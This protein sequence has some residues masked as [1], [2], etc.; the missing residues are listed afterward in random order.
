MFQ[1]AFVGALRLLY[2]NFAYLRSKRNLVK[3]ST[4]NTIN[5][6][7]Q[8]AR[9]WVYQSN[10]LLTDELIRIL[11]EKGKNFVESWTAHGAALKTSFDILYNRF[12]V[13]S[14]DEQQ[15]QASGCSIDKSI[16]FMKNLE[17]EFQLQLFDRMQ[18]AFRKD[19]KIEVC[20]LS[21]FEK[22]AGS[23]QVNAATIV[24]NNMITNKAAF[25]TSWEI[26]LKESWQKRVLI[27]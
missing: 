25:D 14:V 13:L 3:Q 8:D 18:V 20:S 6:M 9:V 23:G 26:P 1:L 27:G 12:I 15:A 11:K 10:S 24:F 17:Q 5:Q 22:L 7:P 21:E 16:A 19:E 2:K 4:M